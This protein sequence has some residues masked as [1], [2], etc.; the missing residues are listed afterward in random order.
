MNEMNEIIDDDEWN[1]DEIQFFEAI[2]DG[3]L[4]VVDDMINS[5]F[6]P[7]ID[8]DQ[9]LSNAIYYGHEQLVYRLIQDS[10]VDPSSRHNAALRWAIENNYM[11]IADRL[12]EDIRVN[13]DPETPFILSSANGSTNGVANGV[14]NDVGSEIIRTADYRGVPMEIYQE[15][16]LHDDRGVDHGMNQKIKYYL[17]KIINDPDADINTYKALLPDDNLNLLKVRLQELSRDSSISGQT[18]LKEIKK[19]IADNEYNTFY[20]NILRCIG[21]QVS[22]MRE[23]G[24]RKQRKRSKK[25]HRR[26]RSIKR[27]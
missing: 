15:A 22:Y 8:N 1:D 26:K 16:I 23:F 25:R 17:E 9:A 13:Q 24:K 12:L 27:L 21:T 5:G 6:D 20:N 14:A 2:Q 19:I 10:R 18:E 11:Y 7:S 3:N 4:Q